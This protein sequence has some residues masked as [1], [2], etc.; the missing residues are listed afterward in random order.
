MTMRRKRLLRQNSLRF[1]LCD[2]HGA[3]DVVQPK[4]GGVDHVVVPLPEEE[5]ML[6]H[7]V[8]PE[9]LVAEHKCV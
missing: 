7:V 9:E 8:V 3:D 6:D 5:L 2:G 4:C 1:L